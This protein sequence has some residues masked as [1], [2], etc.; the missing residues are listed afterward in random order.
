LNKGQ[1]TAISRNEAAL[2]DA[3]NISDHVQAVANRAA[4]HFAFI[5]EGGSSLYP[6][7]AQKV[8]NLEVLRIQSFDRRGHGRRRCG[9]D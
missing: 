2:G 7:L 9:H 6:T 4:F 8:S 5:E 3:T 1:H